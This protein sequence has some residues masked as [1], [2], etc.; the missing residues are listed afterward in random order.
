MNKTISP[1]S[2]H[3]LVKQALDT[4]KMPSVVKTTGSKGMHVYVPIVRGPMAGSVVEL[5]DGKKATWRTPIAANRRRWTLLS[6]RPSM[7]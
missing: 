3:R 5:R 1:D 6:A 7:S 2:L 4:L